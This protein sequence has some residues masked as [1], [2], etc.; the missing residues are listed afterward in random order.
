[1][2]S[3]IHGFHA[4]A[5]KDGAETIRLKDVDTVLIRGCVAAEGATGFLSAAGKLGAI[6]VIGNDLSRAG[7]AFSIPDDIQRHASSLRRR[8][9][10]PASDPDRAPM[11]MDECLINTECR[12]LK[13]DEC[14]NG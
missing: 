12:V 11:S 2:T 7:Y 13:P 9:E 4:A 8:I 1:M 10:C 5:A 3:T 6:S 14:T